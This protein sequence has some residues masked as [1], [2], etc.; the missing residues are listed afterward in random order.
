MDGVFRHVIGIQRRNGSDIY[1]TES[2][3]ESSLLRLM[4]FASSLIL[5]FGR[6]LQTYNSSRYRQFAKRLSRLVRHTFQYVSDV[7]QLFRED[8][9]QRV[10]NPQVIARLQVNYLNFYN[11]VQSS[12]FSFHF[13]WI[14]S[15]FTDRS[16]ILNGVLLLYMCTG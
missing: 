9:S 3:S 14:F 11:L 7:W 4:A 13:D 10:H 6:G 5:L 12:P 15:D 16:P 2:A 8:A 1:F